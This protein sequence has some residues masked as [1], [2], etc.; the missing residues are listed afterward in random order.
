M[1]NVCGASSE[2][3]MVLQGK[4]LQIAFGVLEYWYRC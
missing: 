3:V 4:E 2:A 1:R